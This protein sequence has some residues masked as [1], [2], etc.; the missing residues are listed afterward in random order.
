M[1]ALLRMNVRATPALDL[2]QASQSLGVIW[3]FGQLPL[4]DRVR[5][6]EPCR[7]RCKDT[8][9][10]SHHTEKYPCLHPWLLVSQHRLWVPNVSSRHV[11]N[12]K[13]QAVRTAGRRKRGTSSQ[14]RCVKG[15]HEPRLEWRSGL[16]LF[17]VSC[18]RTES[19][20]LPSGAAWLATASWEA[21]G[22]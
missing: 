4:S 1:L 19:T 21:G 5:Q 9:F 18:H 12:Q 11:G 20:L 16:R 17:R 6:T 13:D 15:A 3:A 10:V 7:P 8:C 14:G 2:H 22:N